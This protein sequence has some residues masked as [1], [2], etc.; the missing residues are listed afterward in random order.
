M[1]KT[2]KWPTKIKGLA[3]HALFKTTGSHM[4]NVMRNANPYPYKTPYSV[5][6]K[7]PEYLESIAKKMGTL[8]P[9]INKKLCTKA[10][11]DD[12]FWDLY[13]YLDKKYKNSG[14]RTR[15]YLLIGNFYFIAKRLKSKMI[16]VCTS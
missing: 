15:L 2:L 14:R 6:Y 10:V 3:K 9:L 11:A 7:S 12:D 13:Y 4:A 5:L 8:L 16:Y 1:P